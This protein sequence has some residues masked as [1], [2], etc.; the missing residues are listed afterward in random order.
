[1]PIQ[2]LIVFCT[3]FFENGFRYLIKYV[4]TV[5]QIF[6]PLLL[7][8]NDTNTLITILKCDRNATFWKSHFGN[9]DIFFKNVLNNVSRVGKQCGIDNLD[10]QSEREC[11]FDSHLSQIVSDTGVQ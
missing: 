4:L 1:M 3:C 7:A 8:T 10:F 2:H 5:L 11:A 6:S 9:I